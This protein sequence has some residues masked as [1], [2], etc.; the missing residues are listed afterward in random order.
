MKVSD[1]TVKMNLTEEDL[2]K[3]LIGQDGIAII[4]HPS[5][6]VEELTIEQVVHVFSG[7]V[8]NWSEF[9]CLDDDLTAVMQAKGSGARVAF[10][11]MVMGE[12]PVTEN[13]V[14]EKSNA[15]LRTIVSINPQAIGYLSLGFI[16]NSIKPL[17]INGV[18]CTPKNCRSGAYPIVRP[19]YFLTKDEPRGIVEEFI[20]F[21]RSREGQSIVTGE[22]YLSIE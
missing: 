22:G 18:G 16:D 7:E 3:H 10:E 17:A 13:V 4:V 14:I 2:V 1:I 6:P 20:R 5:N 12:N 21:S 8:N 11:D 15:D 19:L 9:G